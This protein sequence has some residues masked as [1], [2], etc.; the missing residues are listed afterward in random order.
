M[1]WTLNLKYIISASY[2]VEKLKRYVIGRLG[3]RYTVFWRCSIQYVYSNL[4]CTAQCNVVRFAEGRQRHRVESRCCTKFSKF[5]WIACK[6]YFEYEFY[7]IERTLVKQ[8]RHDCPCINSNRF[9]KLAYICF[10]TWITNA[11]IV[12][13]CDRICGDKVVIVCSG[14]T[15][16]IL[17][18]GN[19]R[20]RRSLSGPA[21]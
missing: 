17:K 4:P 18:V 5:I 3:I 21:T 11:V 20:K 14:W 8:C 2:G 15:W 9:I 1:T 19:L 7:C 6:L 13:I 10:Q 16:L 12:Y